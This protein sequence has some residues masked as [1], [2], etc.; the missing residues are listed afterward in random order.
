MDNNDP[1]QVRSR[2]RKMKKFIF[3][4]KVANGI[5]VVARLIELVVNFF[6]HK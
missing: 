2:R 3:Y 6:I 4:M 1:N 5:Y